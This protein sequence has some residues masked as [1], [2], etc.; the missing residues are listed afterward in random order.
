MQLLITFIIALVMQQNAVA[1]FFYSNTWLFW[2]SYAVMIGT[3]LAILCCEEA[4]R[5]VPTNYILLGVFTVA[6]GF[7]VGVICLQYPPRIV[8]MAVLLTAVVAIALTVFAF[9]TSIDFTMCGGMV[10]AAAA[11]M[12]VFG[13]VLVFF[14]SLYSAGG[15]IT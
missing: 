5:Q 3:M 2:I 6:E 13:M 4:R 7:L 14:P 12:F 10:V 15:G 8:L 11:I 9:Q 1:T